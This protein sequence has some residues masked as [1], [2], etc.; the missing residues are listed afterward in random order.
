MHVGEYNGSL[1]KK[2]RKRKKA[3]SKD[4]AES[5]TYKQ[6]QKN[7]IPNVSH[8]NKKSESILEIQQFAYVCCLKKPAK[9]QSPA[10]WLNWLDLRN[11]RCTL[12]LFPLRR[13][14]QK[15]AKYILVISRFLLKK[16][17]ASTHTK[18]EKSLSSNIL[19][20]L[21]VLWFSVLQNYFE[22]DTFYMGVKRYAGK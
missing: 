22:L 7:P 4:L 13:W 5:F 6:K 18:K 20:V 1:K 17:Q 3:R 16:K 12:I 19:I 9:I 21:I 10:P 2:K 14:L 15:L 8:N 11:R